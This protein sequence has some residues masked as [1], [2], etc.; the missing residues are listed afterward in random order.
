MGCLAFGVSGL[1]FGVWGVYGF[2]M[3]RVWAVQGVRVWGCLAFRVLTLASGNG[4]VSR[5]LGVLEI[6]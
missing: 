4:R 2:G 3:F 5:V 1:G 6:L